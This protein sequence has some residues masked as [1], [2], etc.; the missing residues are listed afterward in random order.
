MKSALLFLFAASYAAL[1]AT[2]LPVWL[3]ASAVF[4]TGFALVIAVDYGRRLPPLS[5]EACPAGAER[6]PY[7][8]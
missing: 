1:L 3:T 4:L 7:A 2:P 5:P 8:G 6:L